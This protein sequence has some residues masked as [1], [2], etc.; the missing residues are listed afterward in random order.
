ML[1]ATRIIITVA[2]AL[3]L[4]AALLL[5]PPARAQV[6]PEIQKAIDAQR[7]PQGVEPLPVDLF[8]TK[9]FY[10]DAEHWED[11]RYTRCNTPWR[12]D[13]MWV[14]GFVGTWGDCNEGLSAT[15]LKSRYPYKAAEEHYNALLA[16]AKAN[17][18]P[19]GLIRRTGYRI[20]LAAA[21]DLRLLR[22][23]VW[24]THNAQRARDADIADLA[25]ASCYSRG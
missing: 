12:I 18:G 17:G 15:Q 13:Q 10:L 21:R 2:S 8:T 9:D 16:A 25:F 20:A 1:L 4:A 6:T 22:D 5:A 3:A 23:Y 19:F 11:P 24:D 14:R 7:P